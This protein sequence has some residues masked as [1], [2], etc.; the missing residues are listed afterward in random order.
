MCERRWWLSSE[1]G[2]VIISGRKFSGKEW[3]G[4]EKICFLCSSFF[5][6]FLAWKS[7][8]G[9]ECSWRSIKK[10]FERKIKKTSQNNLPFVVNFSGFEPTQ[11]W[12]LQKS[13]QLWFRL[14]SYTNFSWKTNEKT[15]TKF[16]HSLTIPFSN[17]P[18]FSVVIWPFV[19]V[20]FVCKI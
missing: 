11:L 10:S 1:L 4:C 19:S 2:L 13:W 6:L 8:F 14:I 7:C 3:N 9:L 20:Y 18:C 16:E 5:C 17:S 15:W 12:I